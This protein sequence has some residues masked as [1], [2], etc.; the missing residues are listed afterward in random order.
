[1]T[2]ETH[3]T[4]LGPIATAYAHRVTA[5]L[6]DTTDALPY[7]INERLRAARMQALAARKR[8][9]PL[10][11]PQME[12]ASTLLGLGPVATLGG[13]GAGD[14]GAT[15]WRAALSVIPLVALVIGLGVVHD[16]QSDTSAREIAEIDTALLSD[17]LP[18]AAY[19]DPGFAQYLK[20]LTPSP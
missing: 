4:A 10:V 13:S 16:W 5:R 19:A 15:W 8:P 11:Q 20:T 9:Q 3:T 17:D 18:P 1:M 2:Q 14:E 12:G 6:S 7:D